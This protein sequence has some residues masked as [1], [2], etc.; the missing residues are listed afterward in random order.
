MDTI[1]CIATLALAKGLSAVEVYAWITAWWLCAY[2]SSKLDISFLASILGGG[3]Y[4]I[5]FVVVLSGQDFFYRYIGSASVFGV[6][7]VFGVAVLQSMVFAN[8]VL[9]NRL[10][11]F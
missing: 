3:I 8:P 4:F 2:V 10:A 1:R 6:F 11:S 7:G 9:F 5:V